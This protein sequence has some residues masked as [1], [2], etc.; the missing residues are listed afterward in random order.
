MK[1]KGLRNEVENNN[2]IK[3]GGTKFTRSFVNQGKL[4]GFVT[5]DLKLVEICCK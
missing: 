5:I 2:V 1:K 3:I 4:T